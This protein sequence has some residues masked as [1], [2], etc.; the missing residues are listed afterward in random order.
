MKLVR[1]DQQFHQILPHGSH[2]LPLSSHLK[3]YPR[4]PI[5]T[6]LVFDER[7]DIPD[8]VLCPIQTPAELPRT[9]FPTRRQQVGVRT[10]FVHEVPLDLQC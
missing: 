1:Q 3:Y 7:T 4:V 9:V 5:R 2:I 6:I 8:L 10:N